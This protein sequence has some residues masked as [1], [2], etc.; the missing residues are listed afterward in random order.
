MHGDCP[1]VAVHGEVV[2]RVRSPALASSP[3]SRVQEV[4][5]SP[6]RRNV[7]PTSPVIG[8]GF[9]LRWNGKGSPPERTL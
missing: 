3:H 7:S 5:D 6:L 4:E 2:A 8:W 1:P 9:L